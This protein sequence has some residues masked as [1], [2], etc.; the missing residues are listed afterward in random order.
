VRREAYDE[1]RLDKHSKGTHH[2]QT[3]R[4]QYRSS[5]AFPV[6]VLLTF[7]LGV[8]APPHASAQPSF[9][10]VSVATDGTPG[11][12][13]S[14]LPSVSADGR[15]VAFVST[16]SNLVTGD[17]NDSVDVFVRDRQTNT[18]TRVSVT[19]T[20]EER[21]GR[22]ILPKISADGRYVVFQSVAP[23]VANDT[24]TCLSGGPTCEDIYL[25]DRQTG[26]TEILS[27]STAGVLGNEHSAAP[28]ISADGRFVVFTSWASNLVDNDTN[29]HVDVFLRDTQAD[30]TIR[31]SLR[32]DGSQFPDHSIFPMISADGSV[33]TFA[34]TVPSAAFTTP[35]PCLDNAACPATFVY[36]REQSSVVLLSSALPP[37][38]GSALE[39]EEPVA[40]SA[41]G[42]VVLIEQ[43]VFS[44]P[45]FHSRR[46]VIYERGTGRTTVGEPNLYNPP[47]NSLERYTGLSPD[48]R[49]LLQ[50]DRQNLFQLVDRVSGQIEEVETEPSFPYSSGHAFS[51]DNRFVAFET[52]GPV[53]S[54]EASP[55]GHVY[56]LDRDLDG[57]AVPS[58]WETTLGTDPAA[59]DAGL[60]PDADGVTNLEEYQRGSHPNGT[61][62]RYLAEGAVNAFFSTSIAA[63][64]P[65]AE[66][67]T[68]LF[69]FQGSH[70]VNSGAFRTLQGRTRVTLDMRQFREAPE[71]D[72]AT[73]IESNRPIVIDRT[74]RWDSSFIGAHAE[75]A[76]ESPSTTWY[77]AEGATHGS[78]DLFYLLQNPGDVLARVQV[79]Y[80]RPSPAEP[81]VASYDVP[82]RSRFTIPVDGE[83]GLAA[84]DVGA[85]ITSDQPII[86][87]RAMYASTN[88]RPFVAGHEGAAIKTPAPR[89]LLAEGATGSFFDLYVLVANPNASE[90][91]ID[92]TYL[93]PND[94]PFT[95]PY[96]VNPESRLTISVD[97]EDPRL[98][99]TPV[100]VIVE[101]TNNQPVVVERAMWWPSPNWYEAHLSAGST[102]TGTRWGLAEGGAANGTP[103]GQNGDETYVLIANVSPV[104]GTAK[105][106]LV[107]DM[108][109]FL[110]HTVTLQPSSRV[111]V[112]ISPLLPAGT[113]KRFGTIVESN[114]VELVVERA[115]YWSTNGVTWSAGTAA[116]ATKL[117]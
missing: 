1:R 112:P 28:S 52:A 107:D 66:A 84:T 77:L 110:E 64:N 103:A 55:I 91:K 102:T 58:S 44:E 50:A 69:Q 23:L 46:S 38:A 32:T 15:F 93:L 90:S 115:M 57:D 6:I 8:A 104:E 62:K 26:T 39:G 27:A 14:G 19:S 79:R 16:A 2:M 36:L 98:A 105:I 111:S 12:N 60:D 83:P 10:L 70:G 99:N 4:W 13:S 54:G 53:L 51:V 59:A 88:D 106:T 94:P 67:A 17:T 34:S 21:V 29:A 11:N 24:N 78:F 47:N 9:S 86:V 20:G 80:L 68:V 7:I 71:N 108:G 95:K 35:Q 76:I 48:G 73:V 45:K 3:S 116:L 97:D 101:T 5:S 18:T 65:N 22:S 85:A 92:V 37:F 63:M 87:E 56:V 30:T 49:Y 31:I 40:I 72:F 74:M 109:V 114:G 89:W 117:Q 96:T 33:V 113:A 43:R 42:Q 82:A 81:I 75:T 41:D 61:F 100:A 25:H